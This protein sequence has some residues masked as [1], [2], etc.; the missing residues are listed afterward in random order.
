MISKLATLLLIHICR[1]T[2]PETKDLQQSISTPSVYEI[3]TSFPLEIDNTLENSSSSIATYSSQAPQIFG[4]FQS[5]VSTADFIRVT[6]PAN[7]FPQD[8]G[9]FV[10]F[11][12]KGSKMEFV[13]Q[14][15]KIKELK[16]T[17][18]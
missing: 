13:D 9:T 15:E 17:Q 3:D 5:D 8:S 12:Q 7:D 10:V 1:S 18:I 2:Q 4:D 14:S 16:T 6:I 11:E